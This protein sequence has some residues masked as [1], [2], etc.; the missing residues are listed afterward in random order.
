MYALTRQ[1]AQA[2][3]VV[4]I[5]ILSVCSHEAHVLFDHDSTHSYVSLF[6][7]SVLT[8]VQSG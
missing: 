7:I 1:D 2:S 8:R 6:F 5:G 3:N 4:V